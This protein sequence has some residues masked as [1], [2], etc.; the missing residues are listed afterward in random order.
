[1]MATFSSTN[2]GNTTVTFDQ[3]GSYILNLAV[4]D[5]DGNAGHQELFVEVGSA[6][7]GNLANNI[8][9]D[10]THAEPYTTTGTLPYTLTPSVT[11]SDGYPVAGPLSE[12]W[13]EL[14]TSALTI[15]GNIISGSPT[16][17]AYDLRMIADD[18]NIK[19]FL[20]TSFNFQNSLA[21]YAEWVSEEHGSYV[22]PET[23]IDGDVVSNLMEYATGGA[24]T[25]YTKPQGELQI[26]DDTSNTFLSLTIV[27][28]KDAAARGL[29]YTIERSSNLKDWFTDS[30]VASAPTSIDTEFESVNYKLTIPI[31]D[32]AHTKFFMRA[33]IKLDE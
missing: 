29:L 30:I 21:Y 19:T 32:P 2:T 33:D 26:I 18:G 1:G 28:R 6:N 14:N 20:D 17:G 24:T 4:T 7:H 3:D 9:P 15:T 13:I 23:D 10:I 22:A 11:D 8:G 27:R 5:S 25:S 12:S 16:Q 31:E